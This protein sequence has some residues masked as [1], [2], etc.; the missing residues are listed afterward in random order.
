MNSDDEDFA[1]TMIAFEGEA[2]VAPGAPRA[3]G[4]AAKAP[5]GGPQPITKAPMA[6]HIA[7]PSIS[8]FDAEQP[9][10]MAPEMTRPA[11]AEIG[12]ELF[13]AD[14]QQLAAAVR[15]GQAHAAA[16]G[17]MPFGAPAGRAPAAAPSAA[18][19]PTQNAAP[20]VHAPQAAQPVVAEEKKKS[21]GGPSKVVLIV[22]GIATLGIGAGLAALLM[23]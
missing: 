10:R 12:T 5:A 7:P 2:P 14:Q 21:S 23:K 20:I 22:A 6:A 3:G 11:E 18:M 1:A 15:A 17:A 9:T 19:P 16:G 4:A 13:E 8:E